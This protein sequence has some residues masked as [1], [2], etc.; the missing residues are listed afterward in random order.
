MSQSNFPPG[1]LND[2]FWKNLS[3]ATRLWLQK[4]GSASPST[5]VPNFGDSEVPAGTMD[6]S[7]AHFTLQNAPNPPSSLKLYKNGQKLRL[8]IGY[9]LAGNVITFQPGY[10][11]Q[12]AGPGNSAADVIEADYRH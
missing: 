1:L 7:N 6:G 2:P 5:G 8:G 4:L 10:I 3:Q 12:P 9:I 11:P